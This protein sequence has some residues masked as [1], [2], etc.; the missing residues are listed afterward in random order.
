MED[1]AG[2][3]EGEHLFDHLLPSLAACLEQLREGSP[4]RAEELVSLLLGD[5]FARLALAVLLSG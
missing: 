2:G 5:W 4:Q 3:W 1:G